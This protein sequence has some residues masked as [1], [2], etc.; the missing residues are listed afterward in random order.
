MTVADERGGNRAADRAAADDDVRHVAVPRRVRGKPVPRRPV[1]DHVD[2]AP[3]RQ[4]VVRHELAGGP[5]APGPQRLEQRPVLAQ[6][7]GV[8][9]LHVLR[10]EQRRRAER[11]THAVRH[12]AQERHAGRLEHDVVERVVHPAATRTSRPAGR[13]VDAG[14]PGG[15]G[16]ARRSARRPAQAGRAARREIRVA[17]S[18]A[19]AP[20]SAARATIDWR[21][22]SR[23]GARTSTP[24]LGRKTTSPSA[25][26]R[27][28]ASRIGVRLTPY[29]S[30]SCSWRSMVPG[31]SSPNRIAA[32]GRRRSR[33]PSSSRR[34]QLPGFPPFRIQVI[35]IPPSCGRAWY[36]W[37]PKVARGTVEGA[38]MRIRTT[39]TRTVLAAVTGAALVIA[40]AGCG[41]LRAAEAVAAAERGRRIA[42]AGHAAVRRQRRHRPRAG[43]AVAWTR[44][45][46]FDNESIWVFEQIIEPL[47]TVARTARASSRGWR[48]AT[49]SRPTRRPT[50]SSSA[51]ASSSRTAS[52]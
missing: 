45:R 39:G 12:P 20:S 35:Q 24:R 33:R 48:P 31:G 1:E 8:E 17:A 46:V 34:P 13:I 43:L 49:R 40:G 3:G 11:A 14:L 26:S 27:R 25:S 30:A 4:D 32:P 6:V 2:Q 10:Q 9:P 41:A 15:G 52:P 23:E 42:A 21:S 44:P 51:R 16:S 50:R 38:R 7:L 22:S 29:C 47:Y 19:A 37:D 18:S 5:R 28:S 36:G